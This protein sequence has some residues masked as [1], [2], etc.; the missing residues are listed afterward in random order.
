MRFASCNLVLFN[1]MRVYTKPAC[2][3]I[4]FALY[5]LSSSTLP[6]RVA[7]ILVEIFGVGFLAGSRH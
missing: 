6:A 1:Y 7:S 5:D 4:R 3:S 2:L